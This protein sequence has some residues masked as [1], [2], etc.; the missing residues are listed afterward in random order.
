MG[1]NRDQV[2]AP[3]A[4]TLAFQ[5]FD[6]ETTVKGG[7]TT[8]QSEAVRMAVAKALAHYDPVYSV[9]LSKGGC[10]ERV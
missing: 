8:G 10:G 9:A 5:K 4:V 2:L 3:L 6:V 1:N 7:G